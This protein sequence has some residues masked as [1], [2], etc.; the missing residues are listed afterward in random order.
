VQNFTIGEET[1]QWYIAQLLMNNIEFCRVFTELIGSRA[2]V[3][4]RL[5]LDGW[6]ICE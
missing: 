1:R 2:G 6:V 5:T 4:N 3:V